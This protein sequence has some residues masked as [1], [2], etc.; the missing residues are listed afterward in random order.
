MRE[1]KIVRE[2]SIENYTNDEIT[3]EIL[4]RLMLMVF[5]T[6]QMIIDLESLW[7]LIPILS[8]HIRAARFIYG[9]LLP[10]LVG[11]PGIGVNGA[12]LTIEVEVWDDGS[13]ILI[14]N[15]FVIGL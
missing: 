7:E 6:M 3:M 5:P 4:K 2:K 8:K 9:V 10:A 1:E 12:F 15:V 14:I 13:P 11:N